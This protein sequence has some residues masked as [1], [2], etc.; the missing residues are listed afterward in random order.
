MAARWWVLGLL[1]AGATAPLA[2]QGRSVLTGVVIS[3]SAGVPLPGANIRIRWASGRDTVLVANG[4]GRFELRRLVAGRYWLTTEWQGIRSP[5]LAVD[6]REGE[7][8]EAEFTVRSAAP[9]L[10]A[11]EEATVL[12]DLETRAA[13]I[14]TSTFEQRR[15]TGLGLY[16]TQDEIERRESATLNELLRNAQGIR[17]TCG[18][19]G[20][21]PM[22]TRAPFGCA[23]AFYV[24]DMLADGRT[25]TN[26]RATELHGI[27]IYEGVSQL[28]AELVRDRQ[29]ARCGVIAVWTRRGPEAPPATPKP[30]R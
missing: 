3:D 1:S 5:L 29:R 15:L 25:A 12:P 22:L 8:F 26:I 6:L 19:D 2:G 21:L 30:P 11:A 4:K 7:R 17:I 27:E 9:S 16:I 23:P 10:M 20:C 14:R 24:D 28:P 18:R 13:P